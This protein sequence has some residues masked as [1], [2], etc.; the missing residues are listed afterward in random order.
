[1]IKSINSFNSYIK[2]DTKNNTKKKDT[3]N[4]TKP[5]TK[6]NSEP[7]T[8]NNTKNNTEPDTKNKTKKK[9]TKNNNESDTKNNAKPY[10]KDDIESNI[11]DIRESIR[12]NQKTIKNRYKSL[13][14]TKKTIKNNIDSVNSGLKKLPS[15][16]QLKANELIK[17]N[18][19]LNNL[20]NVI[21]CEIHERDK[22][23]IKK[24]DINKIKNVGS[25]INELKDIMNHKILLLKTSVIVKLNVIISDIKNKSNVED[26][27]N[28]SNNDKIFMI[29]NDLENY[30]KHLERDLRSIKQNLKTISAYQT[31]SQKTLMRF[32]N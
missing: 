8:K 23:V 4:N 1:M 7:D 16:S 27:Y 21:W 20:I 18:T 17:L 28:Y 11:N 5:D 31:D 13:L 22:K 26:I 32:L 2:S 24:I 19:I 29:Y 14:E 6:N 15:E 9:D 10:T 30:M 25:F 12:K 3:K